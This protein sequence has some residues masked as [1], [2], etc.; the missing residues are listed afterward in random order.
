MGREEHPDDDSEAFG[1][2][3]R[4]YPLIAKTEPDFVMRTMVGVLGVIVVALL[5]FILNASYNN[6]RELG[7]IKAEFRAT[8]LAMDR[9]L[10]ALEQRV[11]RNE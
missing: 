2:P 6:N 5:S 4:N 8:V 11:W 9:R 1:R 3:H 10:A 7:E